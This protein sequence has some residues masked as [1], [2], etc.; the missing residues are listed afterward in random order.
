MNEFNHS[1][2][3]PR[4]V[5]VTREGYSQHPES[6][7]RA[8]RLKTKEKFFSTRN[9]SA[10][11]ACRAR[12]FSLCRSS[13]SLPPDRHHYDFFNWDIQLLESDLSS[14]IQTRKYFLIGTHHGLLRLVVGRG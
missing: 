2:T 1:G 10:C 3:S 5:P 11:F 13:A 8:N 7:I 4:L 14:S 12:K 9:T 6:R